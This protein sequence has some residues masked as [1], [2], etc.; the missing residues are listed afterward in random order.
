MFYKKNHRNINRCQRNKHSKTLN[1]IRTSDDIK[2][3]QTLE[4]PVLKEISDD[5]KCLQI[6]AEVWCPCWTGNTNIKD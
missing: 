6:D 3:E 4:L 5:E 1:E 2:Q